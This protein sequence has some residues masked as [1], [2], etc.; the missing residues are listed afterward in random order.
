MYC[1]LHGYS[2]LRS[3]FTTVVCAAQELSIDN[4][5]MYCGLHGYSLIIG[6][7]LH[8][9]RDA[10][11]DKVKPVVVICCCCDLLL[12]R[13]YIIGATRDGTRSSLLL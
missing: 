4:K 1:G 9:W 10:G 5:R 13:T 12:L 3:Y 8:H 7:D 2:L 11:W 6:E